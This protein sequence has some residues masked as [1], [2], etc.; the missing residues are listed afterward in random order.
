[1]FGDLGVR[2]DMSEFEFHSGTRVDMAN[3]RVISGKSYRTIDHTLKD[4]R[5]KGIVQV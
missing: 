3:S 2:R 5:V 4:S 1:M